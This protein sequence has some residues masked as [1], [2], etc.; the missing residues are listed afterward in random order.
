MLY[1]L[2]NEFDKQRF[3]EACKTMMSNGYRVEL[4]RK[5][6]TRSLA[7]NSYLH[8][9]LGYYGSEFGLTLEEVKFEVFK[10]TCN[11]DIFLR[12]RTNK[13]GQT[14]KY[15][16][17]SAELDTGEM[18]TAI[19]R[20]RNYSASVCGL[21]LPAPNE[22]EMLFYAQQQIEANKDYI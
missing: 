21:Y 14:I 13:R 6:V 19:E 17:S 20:F 4:K 10:K 2:S 16:R 9:L 7:Q 1:N 5:N 22:G 8:C 12:E 11:K 15:I 18:T 3:E